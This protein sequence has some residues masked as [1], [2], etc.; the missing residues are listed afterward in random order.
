MEKLNVGPADATTAGEKLRR[1]VMFALGEERYAVDIAQVQEVCRYSASA[2]HGKASGEM[3][4]FITLHEHEVA[5]IDVSQ[6]L[7]LPA[8]KFSHHTRILICS[9]TEQIK[10]IVVDDI[11]EVVD[12]NLDDIQAVSA[13]DNT[14]EGKLIHEVATY[15][16]QSMRL[17]DLNTLFLLAS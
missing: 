1:V 15:A 4:G 2:V 7:H 9:A 12:L 14:A 6:C 3:L 8:L 13:A 5:L 17:I 10:G 16:G 11:I